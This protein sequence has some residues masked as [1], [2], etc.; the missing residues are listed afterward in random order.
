MAVLRMPVARAVTGVAA[1][2]TN[3]PAGSRP[4]GRLRRE[5][6]TF[7]AIGVVSTAVY[8][9]LYLVLR[10][11]FTAALANAL[12]LVI[13]A[14]GNTATN[15]RLTF[16][17]R[18]RDSMLRHQLGGLIALSMALAITT[19]SIGLLDLLVSRPPRTL[20]LA[21]LVAANA[22]ATLVRFVV[23]RTVIAGRPRRAAPPAFDTP[24]RHRSHS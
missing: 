20:E 12:A 15:R 13:T 24:A 10:G 1:W 21:V 14:I 23:L 22:T 8:A 2:P 19:T 11:V 3:R 6:V 4:G 9:A 16:G 18:R 7:A 5:V 17:V